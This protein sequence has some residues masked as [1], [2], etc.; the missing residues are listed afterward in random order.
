[1]MKKNKSYL[2]TFAHDKIRPVPLKRNSSQVINL[3]ESHLPGSHFVCYFNDV[4]SK[5]IYYFDSYGIMPSNAIKTILKKTGKQIIY[6]SSQIQTKT[7]NR[8]GFY[9]KAFIDHMS[10]G[11]DYLEFIQQFM[12]KGTENDKILIKILN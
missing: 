8:C 1:M 3:H 4:N 9:C 2:G 11:K 5:F 10:K 12:H 6:N 7:S